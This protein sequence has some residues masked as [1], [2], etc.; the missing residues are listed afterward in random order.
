MLTGNQKW[1]LGCLGSG[2]KVQRLSG[3]LNVM[4]F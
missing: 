2:L 3:T 4:E 1:S